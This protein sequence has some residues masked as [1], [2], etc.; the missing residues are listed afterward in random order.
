MNVAS[1]ASAS[2]RLLAGAGIASLAIGLLACTQVPLATET[3]TVPVVD[4]AP[5][6]SQAP[7]DVTATTTAQASTTA[8]V[9]G[10]AQPA[11]LNAAVPLAAPAA[12]VAPPASS[13]PNMAASQAGFYVNV[14]VFAVAANASKVVQK[15]RGAHFTVTTEEVTTSKGIGTRVRVGPF[16]ARAQADKA[17]KQVR[18]L[19]L[20][21]IVLKV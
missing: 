20:D 8:I 21:A 13:P 18:A 14:G 1:A 5:Q 12:A 16:G 6:V 11:P 4:P 7:T 2:L 17:A 9:Q 15:L 3:P 19:K 10:Q